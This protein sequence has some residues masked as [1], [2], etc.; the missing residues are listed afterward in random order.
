MHLLIRIFMFGKPYKKYFALAIGFMAVNA[1]F[2]GVSIFSIVPF[3][4]KVLTGKT[5]ELTTSV[6]FPY[7]DKLNGYLLHLSSLDRM[8]VFKYLAV[9]LLTILFIKGVAFYFSRVFMEIL[10]QNLVKDIRCRIFDHVE[11]LSIDFFS[12]RKTGELMS[13]V[14]ADVQMILD[15]VSSRFATT[16]IEFPKFI[17]YAV[18][19][20]II[21]W[22]LIIALFFYTNN[23]TSYYFDRQK[24]S[25]VKPSR[26]KPS[27]GTQFGSFRGYYRNKDSSGVFYGTR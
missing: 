18:I 10:G 19:L 17:M 22:K 20:L 16:L 2:E 5:I 23:N 15:I 9:F 21:D 7:Q 4:D 3:I 25:Q 13:R 1:L 8:M 14:S 27:R 12:Q 11:H 26:P 6:Q 24:A